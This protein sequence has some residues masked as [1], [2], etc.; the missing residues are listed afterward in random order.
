MFVEFFH[1]LKPGQ[2]TTGLTFPEASSFDSTMVQDQPTPTVCVY[3]FTTIVG[4]FQFGHVQTQTKYLFDADN[5][6]Y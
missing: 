1:H 3:N 5:N 2:N 6:N 4:N